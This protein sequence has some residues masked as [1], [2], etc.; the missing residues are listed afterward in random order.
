VLDTEMP[1]A[2]P[3]YGCSAVFV[4]FVVFVVL[5]DAGE[6]E[7]ADIRGKAMRRCAGMGP[8]LAGDEVFGGGSGRVP[9]RCV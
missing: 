3:S 5:G 4:V 2:L 6:K 8:V 9:M 7:Q 1:I